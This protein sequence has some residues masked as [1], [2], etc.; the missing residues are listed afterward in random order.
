VDIDETHE[1]WYRP[2]MEGNPRDRK[3]L[4][5]ARRKTS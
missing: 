1:E 5:T 4:I 3:S 2:A